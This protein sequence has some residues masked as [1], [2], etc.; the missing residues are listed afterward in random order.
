MVIGWVFLL[1]MIH[2]AYA[3]EIGE[4]LLERMTIAGPD[5]KI[6]VIIRFVD[7][8]T[9]NNGNQVAAEKLAEL[10][11]NNAAASQGLIKALLRSQGITKIISL[12]IINGIAVELTVEQILEMADHPDVELIDLN[13]TVFA[14][15][16]PEVSPDATVSIPVGAWDNLEAI[17]APVLWDQ[18]IDGSGV[19]VA[20][21][22]T[23]VDYTHQDLASSWRG[24]SNSW[25]DPH[26]EHSLPYDKTGHGTQAMG[27]LVGGDGSG[28][29]IGVAPGARWIAVKL[30]DDSGSALYSDIH[31]GFQWL[32]NPDGLP[33]TNDAPHV[34]NNSW[35]L[36]GTSGQCIT[37]FQED[38][39]VF[40]NAGIAVVFSAGNS[41]P[42]SD[43]SGSPANYPESFAVGAVDQNSTVASF[44]S[45]GPSACDG[46]DYPEVTAPGVDIFTSNK[47]STSYTLAT[48]TSFA[49]PHAAGAM[50]LLKDAYPGATADD[51][52]LALM[53]SAFDHGDSGADNAYGYGLIDLSAAV[54]ELDNPSGCVDNDNDGYFASAECG[55]L[56]DCNDNNSA[57]NPG[58]AE[59]K[60]DGIDQNCNGY[61]LT[62]DIIKAVYVA[63]EDK[64]DVEA[65]SDLGQNA[66]LV[67]ENYGAMKW[68]RKKSA[69]T[70]SVRAAGGDP[71][72]VIVSGKEGSEKAETTV[73]TGSSSPGGGKGKKK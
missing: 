23:G 35:G 47:G 37:E 72:V 55:T 6:P 63:S 26:G 58:A 16:V 10:L 57:I 32:L 31:L 62:I 24:G 50:A 17:E 4:S 11:Q 43:T 18:G 53:E 61:D 70:I 39:Q 60:G 40:K 65:T 64:L 29:P 1:T 28:K 13:D 14:P 5:E 19:V 3:G 52:E 73:D 51:I 21:M 66:A 12:W 2:P 25:Y 48:G 15:Q 34:V 56:V 27:I 68:D 71:G 30:F 59:I 46:T 54:N 36:N 20:S 69:W 9:P 49:A 8:T 7:K 33:E 38:V 42:G 41:G 44:S 22:D 67:L 45:R